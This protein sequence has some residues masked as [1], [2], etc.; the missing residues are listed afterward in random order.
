MDFLNTGH[1]LLLNDLNVQG[2]L[3]ILGIAISK[4]DKQLVGIPKY[5][6]FNTFNGATM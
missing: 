5:T 6:Y 1:P 3:Q 4:E 2:I